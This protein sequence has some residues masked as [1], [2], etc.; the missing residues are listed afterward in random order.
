MLSN[1]SKPLNKGGSLITIG[2][3]HA[4]QQLGGLHASVPSEESCVLLKQ[5]TIA[6][7]KQ[8][9]VL[10]LRWLTMINSVP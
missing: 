3:Y 9:C 7:R 2:C 5:P 10:L 6:L 1:M 8:L 4:E